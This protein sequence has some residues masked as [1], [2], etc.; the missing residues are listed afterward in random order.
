MKGYGYAHK[1]NPFEII[2]NDNWPQNTGQFKTPTVLKYDESFK[3]LNWGLPA[4]AE[5]PSK[6]KKSTKAVTTELF[7]LHLAK[8]TDKPPLPDKLHHKQ[9]ITD[10]LSQL[11]KSIKETIDSRW[12]NIDFFDNVLLILTIPAEF[13][14][15][16]IATLRESEAA[17]IYCMKVLK[18]HK[19][20]VG[21]L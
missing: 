13:D 21:G 19:L 1:A 8:M 12:Q 7:K 3:V 18:E 5:K 11:N 6:K 20:E 9:A 16:A 4:L 15:S 10:Y 14:D 17:A 2:T